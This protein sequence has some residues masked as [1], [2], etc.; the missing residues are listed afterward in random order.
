MIRSELVNPDTIET[1][2]NSQLVN[3][4]VYK[5]LTNSRLKK[6]VTVSYFYHTV[7]TKMRIKFTLR[8][9]VKLLSNKM[10]LQHD[11]KYEN[12]I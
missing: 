1:K 2:L 6:R 11:I 12:L 9:Q 7:D 10:S 5:C 3:F 8:T 4:Q